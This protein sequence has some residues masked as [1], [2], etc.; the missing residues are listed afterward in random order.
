MDPLPKLCPISLQISWLETCVAWPPIHGIALNRGKTPHKEGPLG[1]IEYPETTA[2]NRQLS[3]V[4][5]W[6]FRGGYRSIVG[7][8]INRQQLALLPAVGGPPPRVYRTK[9][10]RLLKEHPAQECIRRG[11]G[12]V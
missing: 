8:W 3:S 2:N 6:R 12:G 4:G 11:G 10:N 9:K 5:G 7:T 1:V